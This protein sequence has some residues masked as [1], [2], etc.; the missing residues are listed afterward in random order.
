VTPNKNKEVVVTDYPDKDINL[1]K[2][3]EMGRF[4]NGIHSYLADAAKHR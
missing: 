2:G 1:S 3:D 4:N